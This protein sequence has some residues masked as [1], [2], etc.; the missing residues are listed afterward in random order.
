MPILLALAYYVRLRLYE[1]GDEAGDED[2]VPAHVL[3]ASWL[4]SLLIVE[5]YTFLSRQSSNGY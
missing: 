5:K 4:I 1:D 3:A 2:V